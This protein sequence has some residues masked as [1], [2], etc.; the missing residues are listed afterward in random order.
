MIKYIKANPN[1]IQNSLKILNI[2]KS[3]NRCCSRFKEFGLI[4]F[5]Y[6]PLALIK[7]KS[8]TFSR[9]KSQ[10]IPYFISPKISKV[11]LICVDGNNQFNLQIPL[12][13]KGPPCVMKSNNRCAFDGLFFDNQRDHC[14]Y[15]INHCI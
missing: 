3:G 1:M 7:D 5:I 10:S 9:K 15:I 11:P 4:P 12:M 14:F 2:C 13:R 6:L 8:Y